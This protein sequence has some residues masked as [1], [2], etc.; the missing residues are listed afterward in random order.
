MDYVLELLQAGVLGY[1]SG[2]LSHLWNG[3]WARATVIK[4]WPIGGSV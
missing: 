3:V 4:S 2:A 1:S